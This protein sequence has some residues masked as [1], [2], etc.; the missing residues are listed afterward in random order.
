MANW[1]DRFDRL[2]RA[3]S[4]GEPREARNVWPAKPIERKAKP[5]PDRPTG[6]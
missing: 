3:M 6:D 2:L 1:Q 4:K 5:R